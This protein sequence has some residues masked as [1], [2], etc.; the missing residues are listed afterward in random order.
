MLIIVLPR[1][2]VPRS[3]ISPRIFLARLRR[4]VEDLC[5]LNCLKLDI[6]GREQLLEARGCIMYPWFVLFYFV[7]CGLPFTGLTLCI[8]HAHFSYLSHF[9]RYG[10]LRMVWPSG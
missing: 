5:T 2:S 10:R 1:R 6:R 7:K 4:N 9:L 8:Y 3:D